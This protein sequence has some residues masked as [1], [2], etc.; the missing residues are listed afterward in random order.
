MTKHYLIVVTLL[1]AFLT[2]C[3]PSGDKDKMDDN[4]ANDTTTTSQ[5]GSQLTAQQKADGWQLLFDGQTL[6]GWRT[7]KNRECDSWE[8]KDGTI[9]CKP[10]AEAGKRAD[11]MTEQ[12]FDNFELSLEWKIAAAGNSG[13][14]YRATEEYNEPYLTGPEY[15]LLDD[16][17]YP[18][19]TQEVNFAGA[20]YNMHAPVSKTLKPAG[21]WNTTRIVATG[22]HVEHWL[23]GSKVVEYEIGSDDWKKRKESSKWKDVAGYGVP[24]KGHIDLQ[25]HNHE[26]WFRNIMIRQL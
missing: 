20:N 17:N 11:L 3:K 9:H 5:T 16:G 25:D 14:I 8:V 6:S 15:Q 2:G 1:S 22:N 7:F 13:I 26:V 10:Q 21:E 24:V 23:N 12:Q 19:E 18:G 4:Q